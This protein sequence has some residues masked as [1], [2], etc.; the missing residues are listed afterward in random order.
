VPVSIKE[1]LT[2]MAGMQRGVIGPSVDEFYYLARTTLV[3]DEAHFDRFD[4]PLANI[5]KG[6][7]RSSAPVP[8]SR[9]NGRCT[10]A[11]DSRF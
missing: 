6:W 8:I 4:R 3:K 10:L 1:W 7:R 9:S 2:L 5:S 11:K